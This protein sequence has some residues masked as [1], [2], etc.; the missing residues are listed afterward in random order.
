MIISSSGA[1]G[2]VVVGPASGGKLYGFNNISTTP[3][4]VLQSNPQRTMLQFYNPGV[5]DIY[6]APANVQ[7]L[8]AAPT[9]PSNQTLTPSLGAL[10]GCFKVFANGGSITIQGE[11]QGA[12]QAFS[13][14]GTANPLT[15]SES[16]V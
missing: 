13:A 9:T 16:N 8:N 14:T 15:A 3:M 6:I 2:S 12:W 5:V 4:M 7:G 11:C 10:G 1:G